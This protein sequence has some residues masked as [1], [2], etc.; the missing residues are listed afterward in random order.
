MDLGDREGIGLTGRSGGGTCDL[1]LLFE[2][3]IN[4]QNKNILKSL[5][6]QSIIAKPRK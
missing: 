5:D 2:K 6:Y 4:K 3:R 1:D